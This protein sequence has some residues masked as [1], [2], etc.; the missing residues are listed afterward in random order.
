[1]VLSFRVVGAI[2][3]LMSAYS[4]GAKAQALNTG[5]TTTGL[6]KQCFYD[7]AGST[8]TRTVRSTSICPSSITIDPRPAPTPSVGPQYWPRA[9]SARG[10]AARALGQGLAQIGET[11]ERE[12]EA[13]LRW[14]TDSSRM[15]TQRAIV[16][17]QRAIAE[18]EERAAAYRAYNRTYGTRSDTASPPPDSV[19]D[20][21][22]VFRLKDLL[23]DTNAARPKAGGNE[24]APASA[25]LAYRVLIDALLEEYWATP[26]YQSALVRYHQFRTDSAAARFW[27]GVE[28]SAA[29]YVRRRWLEETPR[30]E[31]SPLSGRPR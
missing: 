29:S 14:Q 11:L 24:A 16:E 1:M 5:E 2:A 31:I 26:E 6:T 12:R 30:L 17:T 28:H 3:F 8:Y 27:R 19:R 9:T 18:S 13:R 7:L 4:A 23:S 20:E 25:A 21:R 10:E 22:S 15:A